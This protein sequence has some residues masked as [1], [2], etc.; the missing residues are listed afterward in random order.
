M[1][2]NTVYLVQQTTVVRGAGKRREFEI[3]CVAMTRDEA[4]MA[5]GTYAGRFIAERGNPQIHMAQLKGG[6]GCKVMYGDRGEMTRFFYTPMEVYA[7]PTTK[8]WTT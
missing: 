8:D 3:K 2:D 6:G 7:P 1:D 4:A 5:C